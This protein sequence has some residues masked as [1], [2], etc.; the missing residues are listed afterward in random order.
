M[1]D[2]RN[3]SGEKTRP[4]RRI[5][6]LPGLSEVQVHPAHHHGHQM[7]EMPRRRIRASRQR[8]T[9]RTPA[10]F[11]RLLTLS[12]LRFHHAEST[13][14]RTVSEVRCGIYRRKEIKNRIDSYLH[15]GR[16]RLGKTG[17]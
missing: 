2:L 16:L 17:G 8:W 13:D 7:P 15:Q 10:H 4:F 11:L 9:W 3:Q 5:Y 12:G 6:R 1:P 14:S